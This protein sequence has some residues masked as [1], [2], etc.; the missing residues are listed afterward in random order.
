M[1]LTDEQHARLNEV[2]KT[3]SR[4]TLKPN[5]PVAY[6]IDDVALVVI[7]PEFDSVLLVIAKPLPWRTLEYCVYRVNILDKSFPRLMVVPP[8]VDF[9][10]FV[11]ALTAYLASQPA[12]S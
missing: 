9:A 12:S 4:V 8:W 1:A 2:L 5:N 10:S 7:E 11:E 6:G 3:H